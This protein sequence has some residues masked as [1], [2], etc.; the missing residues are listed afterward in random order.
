MRLIRYLFF[1]VNYSFSVIFFSTP[2][3]GMSEQKKILHTFIDLL[4]LGNL[5]E[6][7]LIR[8]CGMRFEIARSS[9]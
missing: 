1:S 6:Q 8:N 5:P 2:P 3:G 4:E 7:A 9:R